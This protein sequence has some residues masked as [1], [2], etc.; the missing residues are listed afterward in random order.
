M[1]LFSFFSKQTSAPMARERLQVLLAH[2]RATVGHSDLVGLLR[3]EI[4]AV[5]AKHV[6]V[7]REKVIV[8]MDRGEQVST[9][10]VDIEIPVTAS[11]RAA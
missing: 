4:L 10:E 1:N 8:K 2:E 3:E 9:L 7:D 6:Q 11:V 5:I